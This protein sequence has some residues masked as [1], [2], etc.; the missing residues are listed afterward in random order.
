MSAKHS[1]KGLPLPFF[2]K[3]ESADAFYELETNESDV[4][5]LSMAKAGT[6]WVTRILVL[7][8]HQLDDDGTAVPGKENFINSGMQAYPE[9]LP[10]E[11]PPEPLPVFGNQTFPM[12]VEQPSPRLFV[13]HL[14]DMTAPFLPKG[15]T[16]TEDGKGRVV[17]VVR[18]LKDCLASLHYFKGEAKDGW[19]GNEHGP[20][21]FN[22]YIAD[23]CMNAY[24]STFDWMVWADKFQKELPDRVKVF[25]Y[26]HLKEDLSRELD[27]MADFLGIKL[28]QAKKKALSSA[29]SFST[30]SSKSEGK[31]SSILMRKGQIGD[32]RNH[33]DKEHWDEFDKVFQ[34]KCG[35]L[36]IVQPL[37]KY[38]Q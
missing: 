34:D 32:W 3:K 18:N 38:Q 15:L 2:F 10:L 5:L 37:L 11:T 6:S 16:N 9:G 21:S 28:T 30:M 4:F 13:T 8:L 17:L 1:H 27:A 7:L 12:L 22:R 20:G 33:L 14:C 23:P 25:Y 26:E 24:G 35:N 31:A 29:V 36:D 19:L